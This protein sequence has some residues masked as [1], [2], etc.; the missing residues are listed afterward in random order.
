MSEESPAVLARRW[1]LQSSHGALGTVSVDEK[2]AGWPFLSVVPYALT[3][4]GE[5]YILTAGIAQHTRNMQADSRA[6]I[7]I[8]EN[9]GDGDPQTGW[10][11][12]LLG[13]MKKMAEDSVSKEE[14]EVLS[15]RYRER[16]PKADSYLAMHGFDYWRL[17]VERVRF[18]AGFGRITWLESGDIRRNLA[19]DALKEGGPGII[20]HMNKD[21]GGALVLI[22]RA[23][24]ADEEDCDVAEM[25]A[26]DSS[27]FFLKTGQELQYISFGRDIEATEARS[28]FVSLSQKARL[29]VEERSRNQGKN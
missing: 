13:R 2:S 11:L 10:R 22:A 15:A 20:E 26:V 8:R 18:I 7:M 3:A 27:G 24:C 19:D 21:H 17:D 5:P 28:V 9:K 23:F 25:T 6:S 4:Q 12:T 29:I 1:L 16:V 14:Y